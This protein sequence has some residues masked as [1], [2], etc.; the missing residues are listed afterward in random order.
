LEEPLVDDDGSHQ[1][2]ERKANMLIR[3]SKRLNHWI[4][5]WLFVAVV[6]SVVMP[7]A[8]ARTDEGKVE[9]IDIFYSAPDSGPVSKGAVIGGLA[10]GVLGHQIGSG[11][12]K[13][14]ATVVGTVGGA[15]VGNE[16]DKKQKAAPRYRITVRLE[17][18]SSL[19]VEETSDVNLKVGDRVRI[20]DGRIHRM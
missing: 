3:H 18:G 14:A 8:S 9:A 19:V 11:R 5:V 2:Y 7:E 6:C 15:V 4:P 20:D 10:G 17:S 16:I 13:T 1:Q 12:G